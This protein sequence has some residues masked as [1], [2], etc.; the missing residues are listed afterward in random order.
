MLT[1]GEFLMI[2]KLNSEGPIISETARQLGRYRKTVLARAS[3]EITYREIVVGFI[4][5]TNNPC[6]LAVLAIQRRENTYRA[7]Q[8]TVRLSVLLN[9]IC[10]I[11]PNG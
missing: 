3:I 4:Q 6:L 8:P 11:I 7:Q 1:Q 5:R 2:H 10:R 9:Q